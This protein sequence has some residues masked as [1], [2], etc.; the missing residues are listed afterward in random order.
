MSFVEALRGGPTTGGD[1]DAVSVSLTPLPSLIARIAQFSV[2]STETATTCSGTV[3]VSG[4]AGGDQ[5]FPYS[6]PALGTG[7]LSK[8]FAPALTASGRG[9]AIMVTLSAIAGGGA[10]TVEATGV[11][12]A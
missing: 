9:V 8:S 2:S 6:E 5:V 12:T 3:T 4:L 1:G 7:A 10:G 11:A